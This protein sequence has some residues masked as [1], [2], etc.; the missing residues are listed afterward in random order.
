MILLKEI[1]FNQEGKIIKMADDKKRESIEK[2]YRKQFDNGMEDLENRTKQSLLSIANNIKNKNND[3][4]NLLFG[5][6]EKA[7][8]WGDKYN[9]EYFKKPFAEMGRN[10]DV[11]AAHFMFYAVS[12]GVTIDELNDYQNFPNSERALKTRSK[13]TDLKD[14]FFNGIENPDDEERMQFASKMYLDFFDKLEKQ[15]PK[16]QERIAKGNLQDII[17]LSGVLGM[18]KQSP[19]E[20]SLGIGSNK[21]SES[22][23]E[24]ID[25]VME[26]LKDKPYR[27]ENATIFLG[28]F[29][30]LNQNMISFAEDPDDRFESH[31]KE[32]SMELASMLKQEVADRVKKG[33]AVLGNYGYDYE[34]MWMDQGND[35]RMNGRTKAQKQN[36]YLD[37]LADQEL[38]SLSQKLNNNVRSGLFGKKKNSDEYNHV[39]DTLSEIRKMEKD[40]KANPPSKE[41]RKRLDEKYQELLANCEKYMNERDPKSSKGRERFGMIQEVAR[42]AKERVTGE[43]G[44]EPAYK[45]DPPEGDNRHLVYVGYEEEHNERM[46]TK[47]DSVHERLSMIRPQNTLQQKTR[48]RS[49]SFSDM[50]RKFAKVKTNK[51][52]MSKDDSSISNSK[53][54]TH[55]I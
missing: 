50:N 37:G 33:T 31:Y 28:G 32:L 10:P 47:G 41:D 23:A 48:P 30:F 43:P 46:K 42:Y 20:Q 13:L 18:F 39:K 22:Q 51:D 14:S 15:M 45:K 17:S 27:Y 7:K 44:F 12:Q 2:D 5:S 9:A 11:T 19:L 8:E 38:E 36:I 26:G 55:K 29:S 52:H 40:M 24:L 1:P 53:K 21:L 4:V 16:I 3:V 25:T 34:K 49:M 6:K 54:R 35:Y